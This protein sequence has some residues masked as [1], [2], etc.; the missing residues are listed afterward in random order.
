[1]SRQRRP[2][3]CLRS[4]RLCSALAGCSSDTNP[5]RDVFV[6]TGVGPSAA[7]ARF[8]RPVAAEAAGLHAGGQSPPRR[9]RS[10]ARRSR[11][12]RPPRLSSMRSGRRTKRRRPKHGRRRDAGRQPQPRPAGGASTAPA[13]RRRTESITKAATARRAMLMRRVRSPSR[14]ASQGPRIMTD[15]HRIKRLPPYVFEQVNRIKAAARAQGAD[16]IDLGMGNP[17]LPA[18]QHVIDKLVRDGRQA[19]HRPLFGLQGHRRPAPRPGR[20]LRAPLRREAQSR[21]AGRRDARLEGRLRQHGPGHHRAGRR[22]AGARTP[23]IR[24]TPSA[25]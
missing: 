14:A 4:P 20:L 16:I 7:G 9:G 1:M 22:G 6:A 12:S 21:D 19:A 17:D 25:S 13:S 10:G 3:R 18:P 5:V 2:N 15:F 23:A 24:S 8:R 11:R